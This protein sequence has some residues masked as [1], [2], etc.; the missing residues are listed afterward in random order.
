MA[1][2]ALGHGSGWAPPA[3][4]IFSSIVFSLII[5]GHVPQN[6][7][8]VSKKFVFVVFI[9]VIFCMMG[10][11][12]E[13][14]HQYSFDLENRQ[15]FGMASSRNSSPVLIGH[16]IGSPEPVEGGS[17]FVLGVINRND[18]TENKP[19]YGKLRLTVKGLHYSVFQP[20]DLIRFKASLR[21]VRNFKTP[22]VWDYELYMALRGIGV[23]GYVDSL[24]KIEKIGHVGSSPY[25]SHFRYMLE[26]FRHKL[27]IALDEAFSGITKGVAVSLVTG[28]RGF[29][30]SE[31]R[32]LFVK[33]GLGHILAVSGLHM[34]LLAAGTGGI[35]YLIL[36][37]F[38]W[39][40]VRYRVKKAAVALSAVA[41]LAYAA[42]AGFSPSAIRAAVMYAAF[43]AAL[44]ADRPFQ[45]VHA[46]V[47]SAWGLILYNPFYL[48]SISFQLSYLSTFFILLL[49][50]T[51]KEAQIS[52]N[53]LIN[54]LYFLILITTVAYAA[55]SPLVM[56]HFQRI[57]LAGFV[58]NVLLVPL[59]SF[60]VIPPLLAGASLCTTFPGLANILWAWSGHFMSWI[61]NFLSQLPLDN[62]TLWCP[63]PWQWQVALS[64]LL[65]FAVFVAKDV[66]KGSRWES[67]RVPLTMFAL[68]AL[69]F[70]SIPHVKSYALK[71][72]RSL[73]LHVLDVG[74]GTCQ[75]L[76]LPGGQVMVVDAGGLRSTLDVGKAVVG[77]FLRSLGTTSIDILALS[78][79]EHDHMGG[80]ASL[81]R[82]FK[83][84]EFWTNSDCAKIEY[85]KELVD[86]ARKLGV[87][88]VVWKEPAQRVIGQ[89]WINILP[90][91]CKDMVFSDYNNNSL[92]FHIRLGEVDMLLPGDIEH[93]RER[94]LVEN[95]VGNVEV[96]VVPH[97]GSKTS[98][99]PVFLRTMNPELAAVS[100]GYNNFLGLPSSD[101][102]RSY[103][104]IKARVFRTD[105]DGTVTIRTD[106]RNVTTTTFCATSPSE[107]KGSL[108][109][110]GKPWAGPVKRSCRNK[111]W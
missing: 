44:Y 34:G 98:S 72:Q 10:F 29:L 74:Q 61:M 36:L 56:Y 82:Q 46:L 43:A 8:D 71:I 4:L 101:V 7:A 18:A 52:H 14:I 91:Q 33:A 23:T 57:S 84:K 59:I 83:V 13:R 25:M 97:H 88:H 41:C 73:E 103:D 19:V 75:V 62:L 21:R 38:T 99:S 104:L 45:P 58:L 64:Y 109:C 6:R 20:G 16:I 80:M 48:F 93:E 107:K 102:L 70:F 100:V 30:G 55:T 35:V 40:A 5:F 11:V 106:G 31:V 49:L 17:R 79:P 63:R 32:E 78:H 68:F 28:Q 89:V 37:R 86:E 69:F 26:K 95:G 24:A 67:F 27:V 111:V 1:G 3:F 9:Q 92:V 76:T 66:S 12:R 60:F 54:K 94:C 15:L 2:V 42:L 105:L 108:F 50:Y 47:L 65:L 110:G 53:K 85:C 22:G 39:L 90:P 77:P 81:L 51:Y 87:K 96:L